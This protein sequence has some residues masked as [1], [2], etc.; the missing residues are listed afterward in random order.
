VLAKKGSPNKGGGDG[1]L[2]AP[3]KS[4]SISFHKGAI[5]V[6]YW[7]FCNILFTQESKEKGGGAKES[8]TK[9]PK[10]KVCM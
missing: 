3:S 4:I 2:V 6:Y 7:N 9:F 10:R 5:E 8:V 1:P